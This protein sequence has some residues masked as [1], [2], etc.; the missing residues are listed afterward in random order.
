[1]DFVQVQAGTKFTDAVYIDSTLG[2]NTQFIFGHVSRE[3]ILVAVTDPDGVMISDGSPGYNSNIDFLQIR[4]TIPGDAKVRLG[5]R[6]F[7][8]QF[9]R[10]L[11][12]TIL[13]AYR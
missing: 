1:M 7:K 3:S 11:W 6:Q 5:V 4:V 9:N 2:K 8:C 13:T 12:S 10:P